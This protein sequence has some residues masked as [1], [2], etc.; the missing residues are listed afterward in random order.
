MKAMLGSLLPRIPIFGA[1]A[2]TRFRF[3]E[4]FMFWEFDNSVGRQAGVVTN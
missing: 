2:D 4:D 1:H 3:R